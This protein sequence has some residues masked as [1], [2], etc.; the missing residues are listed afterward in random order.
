MGIRYFARPVPPGLV[1]IAQINPGAFL[2]DAHFW[3]VWESS[4]RCPETLFLDKAWRDMQGLFG[5]NGQDP[6]RPAYELVRGQIQCFGMNIRPFD[7]VLDPAQV[8]CVASDLAQADMR[9]LYQD[10]LPQ[11]SPDWAAIMDGRR[12]S[13]AHYVADAANF[14][15]ELAASRMGLIYSIG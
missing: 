9:K 4:P 12:D 5:A 1:A 2:D 15:A 14:T 7:R 3:R 11:H 10:C 6:P 13:V 8:A